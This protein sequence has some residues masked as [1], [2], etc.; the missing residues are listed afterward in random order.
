MAPT[1]VV[2]LLEAL[3]RA[4]RQGQVTQGEDR[5][6]NVVEQHGG[7]LG[8]ALVGLSAAVGGDVAHR[9]DDRRAGNLR[10]RRGPLRT[11]ADGDEGSQDDHEKRRRGPPC[12]RG[13][14]PL[15]P[16]TTATR[17]VYEH[18]GGRLRIKHLRINLP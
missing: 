17:G 6:L 9:D 3:C 1:K 4:L 16:R 15:Y 18:D 11:A 2:A 8:A 5:A 10:R 14:R 7:G 12:A 13:R